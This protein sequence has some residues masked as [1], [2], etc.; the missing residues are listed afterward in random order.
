M[1]ETYTDEEDQERQ[2][3]RD[4]VK[5]VSGPYYISTALLTDVRVLVTRA[6]STA[7]QLLN[8]SVKLPTVLLTKRE[9]ASSV[10]KFFTRSHGRAIASSHYLAFLTLKEEV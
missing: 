3:G 7:N 6:G 2:D 8:L 9:R 10:S 1:N 4:D 5:V